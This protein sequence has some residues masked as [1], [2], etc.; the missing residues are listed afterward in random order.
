MVSCISRRPYFLP[1]S[2][3]TGLQASL[4]SLSNTG[5]TSFQ[6]SSPSL[7]PTF[8]ACKSRPSTQPRSPLTPGQMSFSFSCVCA[9]KSTLLVRMRVLRLRRRA[10]VRKITVCACVIPGKL[11]A[12]G[13]YFGHSSRPMFWAQP[14]MDM[15][16]DHWIDHTT[17]GWHTHRSVTTGQTTLPLNERRHRPSDPVPNSH[18]KAH[19]CKE[20]GRLM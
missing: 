12:A 20:C 13:Q 14:S 19:A 8:R 18:A 5:P 16:C 15:F 17:T 11:R 1:I 7:A 3:D 9:I 10:M 6:R 4:Q 2:Q